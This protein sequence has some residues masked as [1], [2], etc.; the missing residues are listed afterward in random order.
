[1]LKSEGCHQNLIH[2]KNF[3]RQRNARQKNGDWVHVRGLDNSPRAKKKQRR[4]EEEFANVNTD[5]PSKSRDGKSNATRNRV[6]YRGKHRSSLR[7]AGVHAFFR[8]S[9]KSSRR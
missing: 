8:A 9:Q 4:I 3:S 6:K 7:G 1:M 5:T 2:G